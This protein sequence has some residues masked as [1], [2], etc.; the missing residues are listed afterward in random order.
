MLVIIM[1]AVC[2]KVQRKLCL[3]CVGVS[4]TQLSLTLEPEHLGP[5]ATNCTNCACHG[6]KLN[7][8]SSYNI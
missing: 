4:P 8:T 7:N 2:P 5:C 1:L 3:Y 6:N